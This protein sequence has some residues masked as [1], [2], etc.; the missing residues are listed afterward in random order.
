[1]ITANGES[2][3]YQNE[4]WHAFGGNNGGNNGVNK[5]L[6]IRKWVRV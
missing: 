6:P 4:A 5:V 1:V 3:E 2:G